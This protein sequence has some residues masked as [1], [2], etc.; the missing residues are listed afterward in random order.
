MAGI[1]N[2]GD[3]SNIQ[4]LTFDTQGNARDI[5]TGLIDIKEMLKGRVQQLNTENEQIEHERLQKL[6]PPGKCQK[7]VF[8]MDH[9]RS[10]LCFVLMYLCQRTKKRY[11]GGVGETY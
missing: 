8:T 1:A 3:S 11:G 6:L 2:D 9:I 10:I 7:K 5:T 4:D